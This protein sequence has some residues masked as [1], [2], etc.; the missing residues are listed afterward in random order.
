MARAR[1]ARVHRPG[2]RRALLAAL[3][4]LAPAAAQAGAEIEPQIAPDPVEEVL[5]TAPEPRYVAPTTRDAIGRIWAPVLINGKGPF[6]LVLDTGASRLG[7]D[8][9]RR[10]TTRTSR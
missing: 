4:L 7:T 1:D 3:A 10:R 5:V 9:A 6:R 2:A 8:P